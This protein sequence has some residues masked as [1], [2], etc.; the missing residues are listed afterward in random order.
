MPTRLI[1]STAF[2]V[3]LLRCR[4]IFLSYP[5]FGIGWRG[6]Y[7]DVSKQVNG[8]SPMENASRREKRG[9][10]R[11]PIGMPPLRHGPGLRKRNDHH[12]NKWSDPAQDKADNYADRRLIADG[13]WP[14]CADSLSARTQWMAQKDEKTFRITTQCPAARGR[15]SASGRLFR[16]AGDSGASRRPGPLRISRAASSV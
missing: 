3:S 5:R 14:P 8:V 12:G 16:R 7:G 13:V 4:A 2:A 11:M 6:T 15:R 10:S 9:R 1:C